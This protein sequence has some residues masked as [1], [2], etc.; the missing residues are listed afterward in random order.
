LLDLR[1]VGIGQSGEHRRAAATTDSTTTRQFALPLTA[2][3][4][5]RKNLERAGWQNLQRR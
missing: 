1:L 5:H 2:A 3:P 4:W